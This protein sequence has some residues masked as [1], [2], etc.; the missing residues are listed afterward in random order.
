MSSRSNSFV[1]R[2]GMLWLWLASFTFTRLVTGQKN[3]TVFNDYCKKSSTCEALKYNTCLGSTLPYTHTSLILTDDSSTQEE[4]FE[5]LVMWSGKTSGFTTNCYS[6][7]SS[8]ILVVIIDHE[9]STVRKGLHTSVK[10]GLHIV[11]V[12]CA[13]DSYPQC[14]PAIFQLNL[15]Y[16]AGIINTSFCTDAVNLRSK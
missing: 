4:A 10:V 6:L 13:G 2:F 11:K 15:A 16:W 5:K 9:L 7:R 14:G 3:D 8:Q 12:M 1:E